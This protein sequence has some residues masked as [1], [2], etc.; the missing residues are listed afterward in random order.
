MA[1]TITR[2]LAR[3]MLQVLVRTLTS[4]Q[5]LRMNREEAMSENKGGLEDML[6]RLMDWVK[7]RTA[8]H[9]LMFAIGLAIGLVL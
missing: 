1:C 6:Q 5:E 2:L 4:E 7:S 9:W 3:S 8:D